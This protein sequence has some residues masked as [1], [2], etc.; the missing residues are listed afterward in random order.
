MLQLG[1]LWPT[2]LPIATRLGNSLRI[3]ALAGFLGGIF[4]NIASFLASFFTKKVATQITIGTSVV[5]VTITLW[6]SFS[7]ILAS[8]SIFVP[9]YVST[10]LSMVIPPNASFCVSAV[11]SAKVIRWVWIWKVHFIELAASR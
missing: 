7:L 5:G 10:G 9:D 2:L 11:L 4:G 6:A 3:P 1:A 8:L